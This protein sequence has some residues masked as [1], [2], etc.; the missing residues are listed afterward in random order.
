MTHPKQRRIQDR[1]A[2]EARGGALRHL[3]VVELCTGV[4]GAYCAKLM[5]DLGAEVIKIE[6]PDGD[7]ARRRGPFVMDNPHPELSALFLHLNTNKLGLTLDIRKAAGRCILAELIPE[8]DVLVEDNAPGEMQ[9][10]GLDYPYMERLNSRL[11]VTSITPFGQAGPYRGVK[12]YQ[13]NTHHS[14]GEGYLLPIH[15]YEP[16]REP[17]KLGSIVADCICGLSGAVATLSATFAAFAFRV[18][19]HIDVSRQDVLMS[20]VQNHVCA[21][22]NLGEVHSRLGRG[23]LTVL[24]IECQDGYIMMTIVT[25]REWMGLVRSMGNPEWAQDEKYLSWIGRHSNAGEINPRIEEWVRG[26][27][28]DDLFRILQENGVAVVPVATSEDL[29]RSPQM[30]ERGFFEAVSHPVAGDLE[31]PTAAYQFSETPWR[32]RAGAPL[33]GQD[34]ELI[35]CSR[36]GY[37]REDLS[38]LRESGVI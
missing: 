30:R 4:S 31:Y 22:A 32:A 27:R 21:Y 17:V 8:A 28:K 37:S 5:A 2:R 6:A 12:A 29:A 33:L 16:D 13:L 38:R 25:D 35:L 3:R 24:P 9:E 15:S 36:L 7:C 34:N 10:L 19:Q 20:L 11:V 14:G 18:G 26:Y 23:F 1:D